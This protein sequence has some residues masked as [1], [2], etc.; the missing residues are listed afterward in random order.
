MRLEQFAP[1]ADEQRLRACHKIMISGQAE[2]DPNGLQVSFG[3]FR[4]W[5]AYGLRSEPRE[6]WLAVPNNGELIGCYL[7]ELPQRE[8]NT[9]A[10]LELGISLD[11]RRR[12]LGT[13]LLAHSLERAELA[14]RTIVESVCRAGSPGNAFATA[15][16]ARPGVRDVRS[17]LEVGPKLLAI[18]PGLRA[19]ATARASG[20]SLR[21]WTGP[22]PDDLVAQNAAIEG[23]MAD[24]PHEDWF[25]PATWDTAR[26]RLGEQRLSAQGVRRYSIAAMHDATGEMAAL[27]Q[28]IV[29]PAAGGWAFQE[30]TAVVRPHRGHRL[31]ILVKV[32]MLAQLIEL[33]PLVRQVMTFN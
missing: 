15:K 21:Y 19:E 30:M 16:D 9:A 13:A 3:F 6:V 27:T 10:F 5:W 31:G 28:L 2:D 12:G 20:Y 33:E 24:A 29:D 17:V 23:A 26:I 22:A 32:A 14:G 25:E 8:N 11:R 7:L 18:L 1:K 4:G